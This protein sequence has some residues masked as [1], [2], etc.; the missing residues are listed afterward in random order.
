MDTSNEASK[1]QAKDLR[2]RKDEGSGG[3]LQFKEGLQ[4]RADSIMYL[5][6]EG[7]YVVFVTSNENQSRLK[8]RITLKR[9]E[10][11]LPELLFKRIHRA[12]IV[13]LSYIERINGTFIYMK[14]GD[15][16]KISRALK[17]ELLEL[18]SEEV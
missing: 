2:L 16:L 13:N 8:E 6:S 3:L 18:E 17:K 4:L 5:T 12:V 10:E 7:N 1:V 15:E 11:I 9:C 14:N